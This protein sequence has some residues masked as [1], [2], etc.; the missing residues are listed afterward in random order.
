[1]AASN[2]DAANDQELKQAQRELA[3]KAETVRTLKESGASKETLQPHLD[4]LKRLKKLVDRLVPDMS[5]EERLQIDRSAL[6]DCCAR[7]FFFVPAFEI[8][9]GTSGLYDLGPCGAALK[10][11]IVSLWRRHFVLRENML[12]VECSVLTPHPVLVSSGHVAR[13]NDTLVKDSKTGDA[14]RA[15]HVLKDA[16]EA[17]LSSSATPEAKAQAKADLDVVDS[18]NCE[19]LGERLV[20]HNIKAPVT[21]NDLTPPVPFQLMF[22]TTIGPEGTQRAYLRPETAQGIF[23]CFPRLLDYNNQRMPFAAAQIGNSYRNEIAPRN[24]LLRVREF[25]Q[26]E[27]EH[28]VNP[29]DK[30]HARFGEIAGITARLFPSANQLGDRQIQHVTFGDAV[31][32]RTINNETLAYFLARTQLFFHKVGIK[33][34]QLRFR[35]HLPTEMAHYASDCWDAEINTSYGW[36]EVAGHADRSCYDLDSH[37]KAT[38]TNMTAFESWDAPR[39]VTVNSVVP[40]KGVIG[41]KFRKEAKTIMDKLA[42]YNDAEV[43]AVKAELDAGR[44]FAMMLDGGIVE[45]T[46]DMISISSETKMVAGKAYVPGVIEPSFGIGRTLYCVLEHVFSSRAEDAQRVVLSFPL[47]IA[48]IK[49]AVLPLSNKDTF[50][51]MIDRIRSAL[52]DY[53][54]EHKVDASG[55]MLGRRYARADE[56]GIPLAITIDFASVADDTVTLRDRDSLA[57]VRGPVQAIIDAIRDM[58]QERATWETVKGSFPAF[59][60]ATEE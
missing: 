4:E 11:N 46:P 16:L 54:I 49:V 60:T 23:C 2:S 21:G 37:S 17:I 24:S 26:A 22:A 42:G 35:Q 59:T 57:Q 39:Q 45:L 31:A 8:Y 40:N 41:K 6:T 33:P 53:G 10:N 51:P 34:D 47:C 56:I 9:G 36:V 5:A 20:A 29:E 12:E 27:I 50:T 28:F 58:C 7:R 3:E 15:D 55:A 19:Q 38:R 1:M 32:A 48:P 13:F 44:S 43:E 18:F 14:F 25:C 52:G 30:R